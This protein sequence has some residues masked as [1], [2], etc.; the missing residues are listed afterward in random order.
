MVR[1]HPRRWGNGGRKGMILEHP[2][3]A[4]TFLRPCEGRFP[5]PRPS[6]ACLSTFVYGGALFGS[7]G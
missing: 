3:K 7:R 5:A 4:S 2:R 1:E 6:A